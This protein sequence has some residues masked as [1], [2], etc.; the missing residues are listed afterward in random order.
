MSL[1]AKDKEYLQKLGT[2]I[3]ALRKAR[4]INQ[5]ELSDKL[6]MDDGS[7][8]RI[9][10]GRTNPTITTLRKIAQALDADLIELFRPLVERK[11]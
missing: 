3:V 1:S 10:S 9:E 5:R 7:L 6:D 2:S 11:K 4:G 8:R